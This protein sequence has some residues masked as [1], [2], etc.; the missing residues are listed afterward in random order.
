MPNEKRDQILMTAWRL[1]ESQGYHATGINQIIK[2]SGVPK[3]SFY[4]YFPE[5]KEGL[6]VEAIGAISDGIRTRVRD[7]CT[8]HSDRIAAIG[9]MFRDIAR[10]LEESEYQHGGPLTTVASETATT[11]A[12]INEAC[13]LAYNTWTEEMVKHLVAADFPEQDARELATMITTSLEGGIIL[14]RTFHSTEPLDHLAQQI[15]SALTARK[16]ILQGSAQ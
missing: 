9:T 14:S 15:E 5:G 7:L 12:R 3:G 8:S 16:K 10:H 6:A 4:H 11:N 2:E 1:F 13:R